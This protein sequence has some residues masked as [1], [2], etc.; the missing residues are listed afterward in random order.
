MV[1]RRIVYSKNKLGY[2]ACST[3]TGIAADAGGVGRI[4][5]FART[6]FFFNTHV[7]IPPFHHPHISGNP[8]LK[9]PM[10]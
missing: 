2:V 5:S 4:L 3:V 6:L 1:I 7:S 10:A 9:K 8:V